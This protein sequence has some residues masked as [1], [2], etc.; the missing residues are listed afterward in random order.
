MDSLIQKGADVN[1]PDKDGITPLFYVAKSGNNEALEI[2]AKNGANI[3]AKS[4]DGSNVFHYLTVPD[5]QQ[6]PEAIINRISKVSLAKMVNEKNDA[7][8][9][10]LHQAALDKKSETYA[11]FLIDNGADIKAKDKAGKTAFDH[12]LENN[13]IGTLKVLLG[14][15]NDKELDHY[16][17]D[18]KTASQLL[19]VAAT[20]PDKALFD[21]CI[22]NQSVDLNY[23]I[24]GSGT[25]LSNAVNSNQLEMVENLLQ[26]GVNPNQLVNKQTPLV[27][28]AADCQI[29]IMKV[30]LENGARADAQKSEA[31]HGLAGGIASGTDEVKRIEGITMLLQYGANPDAKNKHGLT[32]LHQFVNQGN[33]EGI[34]LLLAYGADVNIKNEQGKSPFDMAKE[35]NIDLAKLQDEAKAI[36]KKD[37]KPKT[38]G[39]EEESKEKIKIVKFDE[40]VKPLQSAVPPEKGARPKKSAL[41][42]TEHNWA[43][44]V[45]AHS[46]STT[47]RER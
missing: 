35:K 17:S 30:L 36:E 28:A 24:R 13:S 42:K 38:K 19:L 20:I 23:N 8:I 10:P 39:G 16:I 15:M 1:L 2:L 44:E 11:Q 34:K 37:L 4:N 45:K 41:K 27:K 22:K 40:H 29:P 14:K 26:R 47:S 6:V 32:P 3:K 18:P 43:Q 33:E 12:A 46:S 7:G 31:I 25:P 21:K 9:T 5:K